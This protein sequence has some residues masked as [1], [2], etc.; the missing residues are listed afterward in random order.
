MRIR[1]GKSHVF[2]VDGELVEGKFDK[3]ELEVGTAGNKPCGDVDDEQRCP[4]SR[5][6][7]SGSDARD[8]EVPRQQ[9]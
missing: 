3:G 2:Y 1:D 7:L 9:G 8:C 4:K 5:I 6:L